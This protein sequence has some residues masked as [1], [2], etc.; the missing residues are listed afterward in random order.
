[1]YRGRPVYLNPA[2][3][4]RADRPPGHYPTDREYGPGLCPQTEA[5]VGRSLIVPVGVAY[6]E[7]DCERRGHSRAQARRAAPLVTVRFA[8]V[9]CGTAANHI[10]LPALRA[11]GAEVTVF[12]SRSLASAEATCAAWGSGAVEDRWEDAV[13]RDDVDAVVIATPNAQH[14]AV[15]MA[16]LERGQARAGRQA[17]G[18][19][20]RRCRR[21]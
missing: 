13:G 4:A 3:L 9:G 15:A 2:V 19:H 20:G 14:P 17:D 8:V 7:A 10:H 12:A 11:A 6:S 18:V 5:L 21:R 1:M 16:A